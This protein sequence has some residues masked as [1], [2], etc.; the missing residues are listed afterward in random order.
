MRGVTKMDLNG[1]R[2]LSIIVFDERRHYLSCTKK[3]S[4]FE[5]FWP[6][7][8]LNKDDKEDEKYLFFKSI[9]CHTFLESQAKADLNGDEDK[10][11]NDNHDIINNY[12]DKIF[13]QLLSVVSFQNHKLKR[14]MTT[15]VA[16]SVTT[17]TTIS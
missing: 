14:T 16:K 11:G 9:K 15:T 12:N 13:P 10:G 7:N 8:P 1:K 5:L 17:L 2:G 6:Q 4:D 3:W